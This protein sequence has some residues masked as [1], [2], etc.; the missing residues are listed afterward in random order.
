MLEEIFSQHNDFILCQVHQEVSHGLQVNA[1]GCIV[2]STGIWVELW[3]WLLG[4]GSH[5][6]L[7]S[8]MILRHTIH[9]PGYFNIHGGEWQNELDNAC[10]MAK[11]IA[12]REKKN[13]DENIQEGRRKNLHALT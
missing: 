13:G 9:L 8:G 7:N 11:S 4:W 5:A 12:K 1:L 10:Q 6:M 3:V 2:L